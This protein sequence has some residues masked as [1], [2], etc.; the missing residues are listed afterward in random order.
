MKLLNNKAMYFLMVLFVVCD[1]SGYNE[2][3]NSDVDTSLDADDDYEKCKYLVDA[4]DIDKLACLLPQIDI[5][6]KDKYG[7]TLLHRAIPDGALL[8]V[9]LLIGHGA[10]VNIKNNEGYTPLYQVCDFLAE[11]ILMA[12]ADNMEFCINQGYFD[13]HIA[14][15]DYLLNAGADLS[16]KYQINTQDWKYLPDDLAGVINPATLPEIVEGLLELLS[17]QSY[18]DV[19]E[20][21]ALQSLVRYLIKFQQVLQKN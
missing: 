19:R 8:V 7:N 10:D 13:E 6:R 15:A 5:N 2:K 20:Q 12:Y 21:A 14:I 16:C 18:E 17:K 3:T 1:I 4:C 11:G 9:K